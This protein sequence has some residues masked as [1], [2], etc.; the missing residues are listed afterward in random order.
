[1]QKELELDEKALSNLQA[2]RQRFLGKAVENYVQC[3]EEGGEHDTWV[4][5][6]ASL[7]LENGDVS[8]VNATM[9]VSDIVFPRRGEASTP[10]PGGG[11][12]TVS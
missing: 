2:D 5:R 11:L 10:P 12:V 6:L 3:L 7:W 9:K 1:M 4:F 8:A